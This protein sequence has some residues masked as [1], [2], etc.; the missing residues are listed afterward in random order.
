MCDLPLEIGSNELL[1]LLSPRRCVLVWLPDNIEHPH[2]AYFL[3]GQIDLVHI[4]ST[5]C[6]NIAAI[7]R[8]VKPNL[9]ESH[10][11]EIVC[12]PFL[13]VR[14]KLEASIRKGI[15]RPSECVVALD[16]EKNDVGFGG[17]EPAGKIGDT[18][19]PGRHAVYDA[20]VMFKRLIDGKT[21]LAEE[22]VEF[23]HNSLY[24][25]VTVE[26]Y[27][28][29]N[30]QDVRC[31]ACLIPRRKPGWYQ[32]GG[33]WLFMRRLQEHRMSDADLWQWLSTHWRTAIASVA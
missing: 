26:Y 8:V 13:G 16:L 7:Y 4:S 31:R 24:L 23:V 25:A 19:G 15:I 33:P 10:L 12:Q 9:L 32:G 14:V 5:E 18:V 22:P 28:T 2:V 17:P 11:S 27:C 3:H 20:G 1:K 21:V 30:D 6:L 29:K